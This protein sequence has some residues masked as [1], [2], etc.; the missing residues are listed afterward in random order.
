M[1]KKILLFL[2][3]ALLMPISADA[4]FFKALDKA[5]NKVNNAIEKVNST[6]D[7]ALGVGYGTKF[8]SVTKDDSTHITGYGTDMGIQIPTVVCERWITGSIYCKFMLKNTGTE[9]VSNIV[10]K[11]SGEDVNDC[12]AIAYKN[13]QET[14]NISSILLG[15][16]SSAESVSTEI[17]AGYVAAARLLIKGVPSTATRLPKIVIG[18]SGKKASGSSVKNYTFVVENAKIVDVPFITKE[19]VGPI[20]MEENYIKV[21]AKVDGLYDRV[22]VGK[23][24]EN[25]MDGESYRDI[26]FYKGD[27]EIISATA[28]ASGEIILITTSYNA[29]KIK[30]GNHI[31]GFG[32]KRST[33]DSF[34]DVEKYDDISCGMCYD[35]IMFF[36]TDDD[37][38]IISV[39][40]GYR[41]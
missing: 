28:N 38:R 35:N 3:W 5:L 2:V 9:T 30:L 23:L 26:S 11:T 1:M 34:T 33:I 22:V 36:E 7:N 40:L 24:V 37:G 21:P 16:T 25:D 20:K 18:T 31:F 8:Y 17:P 29:F 39:T 6:I 12:K 15:K 19:R 27:T 32:E 4:Q 41:I 14:Y 13:D 10:M